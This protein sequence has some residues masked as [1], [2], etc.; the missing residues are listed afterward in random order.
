MSE[1]KD[2]ATDPF[3][4][5]AAGSMD[6]EPERIA[7]SAELAA[8][9]S[10]IFVGRSDAYSTQK[11]H[12]D[13]RKVYYPVCTAR[14]SDDCRIGKVRNP[15]NDC[16]ARR[17]AP[18]TTEVM[19]R[20]VLGAHVVGL[21]LIDQGRVRIA[22]VDFDDH[23]DGTTETA[24]AP[25]DA[26]LI[27]GARL[28]DA[29]RTLRLSAFLERSGGGRG[30]HAWLCFRDWVPAAHARKIMEIAL[31]KADLPLNLEIFPRQRDARTFGNLIAL[32]YQGGPDNWRLGRSV[33]IDPDTTAPLDPLSAISA[34]EEALV[35]EIDVMRLRKDH[36]AEM[37]AAA[38]GRTEPQE[39][40]L[41]PEAFVDSPVD[42]IFT[43]CAALREIRD[44]APTGRH[45]IGHRQR[46]ALASILRHIPGGCEAIHAILA[47]RCPG[48]Y[49]PSRTDHHIDSLTC[50][51]MVCGSLQNEGLC[52][53][54]CDAIR[55]R[56]SRSPAAFAYKKGSAPK[57]AET[58]KV[59]IKISTDE[60]AM[61]DAAVTALASHPDVFQRGSYLVS[62][63]TGVPGRVLRGIRRDPEA[64]RIAIVPRAWIELRLTEVAE[65]LTRKRGTWVASRP[66][67]A[68][69]NQLS[70]PYSLPRIRPLI[71]LTESPQQRPDGSLILTPG[72]DDLTGLF[73]RPFEPVTE[74][75]EEPI[76]DDALHALE[77]IFDAVKDFCWATETARSAWL[78][79]LFTCFAR[80]AIDGPLPLFVVDANIRGAGKTLLA[81]I[82]A[83]IATGREAP[84]ATWASDEP[85]RRKVLTSFFLTGDPIILF[86]NVENCLGGAALNAAL[87]SATWRDRILGESRD[88]GTLPLRAIIVATANNA[89]FGADTIRR[90]IHVR[91][92]SLHEHPEDR[93]DQEEKQLKNAVRDRRARLATAALTILRA[94]AHADDKPAV[95]P[96][97]EYV[98]WEMVR[99]M[100][101]WLGLPDP[102]ETQ[103]QLAEQGDDD[104][105]EHRAL[106]SA[107][108]EVAG[109]DWLTAAQYLSRAANIGGMVLRDVLLEYLPGRNGDLPTP[110][111]FGRRLRRF[112]DRVC[113]GW[114]IARRI[115]RGDN[116]TRWRAQP[117]CVEDGAA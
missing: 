61:Y 40:P 69:V 36:A 116:T 101:V 97:G 12:K 84:V 16:E 28:V 82:A 43:N 87:T 24:V 7:A 38:S 23:S 86:D 72:Y 78:S 53:G 50:P 92:H 110:K 106:I 98:A 6:E 85:E 81:Q 108:R 66:P 70:D 90:T 77:I 4:R 79:L 11:V 93:T 55:E 114:L 73:Y 26:P 34:I 37:R 18:M 60:R 109:D 94:Y 80:P 115:G 35:T 48:D 63:I 54:Q 21:Y 56:G 44:G 20:H 59:E 103:R 113:D 104:A 111:M 74:P 64:P 14:F 9:M 30:A 2:A 1:Q 89:Q 29:A 68:L 42:A 22:A 49:N 31:R 112:Q 19:R 95:G 17:L 8:K 107:L 117:S 62:V 45:G 105:I 33:F 96:M 10:R 99:S 71:G 46:I 100:C 65:F 5:Y 76:K 41:E 15:C 39:P 91:L 88:T 57:S 52:R 47:A 67:E 83:I 51:P 75:S 13:G 102:L 32:P 25:Q 58:G 3:A 27:R